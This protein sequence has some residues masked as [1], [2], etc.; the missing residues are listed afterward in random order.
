M[1]ENLNGTNYTDIRLSMIIQD[2]VMKAIDALLPKLQNAVLSA[3]QYL[4]NETTNNIDQSDKM[5]YS[6]REAAEALGVSA[7]TVYKLLREKK[8]PSVK[9]GKCILIS[10]DELKKW[11]T[12][13]GRN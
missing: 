1:I 3:P 11:I 13:Q 9:A 7:Q 8:L 5:T 10:R 2:A 12:N 4:E 6:P